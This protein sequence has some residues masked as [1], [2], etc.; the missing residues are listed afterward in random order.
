MS[1]TLVPMG[2][3]VPAGANQNL[4]ILGIAWY[5]VPRKCQKLGTAGYRVPRKSVRAGSEAQRNWWKLI[6]TKFKTQ[7]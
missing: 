1:G 3:G 5:W 7:G 6:E 4:K 2:T